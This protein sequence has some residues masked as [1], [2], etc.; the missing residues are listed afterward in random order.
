MN[1]PLHIVDACNTFLVDRPY[2]N[3]GNRASGMC[4]GICADFCVIFPHL[5]ARCLHLLGHR[6]VYP[7]RVITNPEYANPDPDLYHVVCL[8]PDDII[9]DLTY[10][11]LD[12]TSEHFYHSQTLEELKQNWLF[13]SPDWDHIADH[14]I[15]LACQAVGEDHAEGIKERMARTKEYRNV[16]PHARLQAIVQRYASVVSTKMAEVIHDMNIELVTL[17]CS[18]STQITACRMLYT[19]VYETE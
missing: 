12:Q 18:Q 6:H 13:I 15:E 19:T 8:L 16:M 3:N 4:E 17:G 2:L 7:N 5:N 9:L 1:L 14:R 10:R 11:Q